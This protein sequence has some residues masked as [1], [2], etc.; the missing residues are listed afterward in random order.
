MPRAC[1]SVGVASTGSAA[2]IEG[3]PKTTYPSIRQWKASGEVTQVGSV[4]KSRRHT[5]EPEILPGIGIHEF[6]DD[7][8]DQVRFARAFV[9]FIHHDRFVLLQGTESFVF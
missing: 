8:Q 4:I 7:R 5:D 3:N 6:P 2:F 1:P 9:A